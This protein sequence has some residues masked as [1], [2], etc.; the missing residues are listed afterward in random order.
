MCHSLT[1]FPGFNEPGKFEVGNFCKLHQ[2]FTYCISIS[3]KDPH[4][5]NPHLLQSFPYLLMK[6]NFMRRNFTPE[7]T[8]VDQLFSTTQMLSKNFITV[9]V[10]L[11]PIVLAN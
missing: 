6:T 8:L 11:S 7:S 9:T 3:C 10:S 2:L 5:K 4:F 1:R